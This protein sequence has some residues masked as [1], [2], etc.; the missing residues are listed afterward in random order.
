MCKQD[1]PVNS[2]YQQFPATLALEK[3]ID[4]LAMKRLCQKRRISRSSMPAKLERNS[5]IDA[6]S[7]ETTVAFPSIEWNLDE[8]YHSQLPPPLPPPARIGTPSS[9]HS[10]PNL[11]RRREHHYKSHLVR[12]K[13]LYSS[14]CSL[15]ERAASQQCNFDTSVSREGS[16]GQFV[17]AD[18]EDVQQVEAVSSLDLSAMDLFHP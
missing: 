15:V 18:D 7:P 5:K 14:L 13:S 12:S 1:T 6:P 16:W 2:P 9:H 17:S 11:K 10:A 3:D 8:S 4:E